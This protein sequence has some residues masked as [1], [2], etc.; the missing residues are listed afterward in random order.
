MTSVLPL[1][2]IDFVPLTSSLALTV[3]AVPV[4]VLPL[5]YP[6]LFVT[7]GVTDTELLLT[8]PFDAVGVPS[9]PVA[10]LLLCAVA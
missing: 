8:V 1:D 9:V 4:F 5:M 2:V 3:T 10:T 7:L 6:A